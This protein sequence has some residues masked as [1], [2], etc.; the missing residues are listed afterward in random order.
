M[1]T[2]GWSAMAAMRPELQTSLSA[3]LFPG[4]NIQAELVPSPRANAR[5]GASPRWLGDNTRHRFDC[6]I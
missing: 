4:V 5:N 3:F 6:G 2:L 1:T